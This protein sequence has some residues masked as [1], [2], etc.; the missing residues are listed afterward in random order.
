MD[1][2]LNDFHEADVRPLA[3]LHRRAFP[4]FFL[5]SLGE[6]FLIQF[7]RGFV[8][9]PS[10]VCVVAKDEADH[11]LGGVVGTVE[12][13]RFFRRMLRR[14]WPGFVTASL[15][16]MRRTPTAMPRLIAAVRYRGGI[17]EDNTDALL[18]SIC[19]EP[20]LHGMGVGRHL[21]EEWTQR[22]RRRGVPSASLTTDALDNDVVNAFYLA[23]GW[24][25]SERFTT[26]QG[27]RMHRYT[28]ALGPR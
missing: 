20:A 17:K 27:R 26:V 2:V 6:P 12:P 13:A 16:S 19:V 24:R 18:S 9:D 14:Q 21:I 1:L 23:R 8:S 10:A 11:L 22:V 4:H 7:Y 15:L 5:S 3:N 28:I 25:V